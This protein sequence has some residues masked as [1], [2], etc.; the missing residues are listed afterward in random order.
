M[1]LAAF[2]KCFLDD[3][4]VH[5]TM[6]VDEWIALAAD[7]L[8]LDGVE[9]Y[10]GFVPHENPAELQRLGSLLAARGLAMPMM[11]CSPDFTQPS[12][13]ERAH[14]V[15]RQTRAIE[16]TA[17]LGGKFC[18]VLS[19]QRRR[20]VARG[21]GVRMAA[22][23]IAAL[24]PVAQ[25]CGVVLNLENHYKDGYWEFPEFAQKMDVFLEL[26]AAIPRSPWFGVNYDPSNA[27]IAGDDPIALLEAVKDRVVT[28]HASDRYFEGGTAADLRR[29]EAHPQLGY[30]P[31]LKHGVIGRGLND[32]DKIFAILRSV[33]FQGWISIE[34]GQDRECGVEHLRLSAEFL[35]GKMREHGLP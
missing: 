3:L 26:L 17:A 16:V 18:R 32:Y 21:D 20:E 30:A 24:L 23:C 1:P 12:A 34:D 22:E 35:R 2:P 6:T 25:R 11:C 33:N 5:K 13:A 8:G 7:A 29:L 31:I 15:E 4:V 14:E 10:W 27:I 19:G 28:M 9:F